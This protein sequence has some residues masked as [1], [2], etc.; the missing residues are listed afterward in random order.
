MSRVWIVAATNETETLRTYRAVSSAYVIVSV[1]FLP[2]LA[3]SIFGSMYIN[4]SFNKAIVLWGAP[5]LLSV[6]WL[7]AFKIE[8]SETT[9]T[10][11]SLFQGTQ[12]VRTSDIIAAHCGFQLG[13]GGGPLRLVVTPRRGNVININAKILSREAIDAVLRAAER[14]T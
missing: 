12:V 7:V 2:F 13:S 9:I 8:I 14:S 5:F 10:F 6:A 3:M 11:R 4:A 1:I